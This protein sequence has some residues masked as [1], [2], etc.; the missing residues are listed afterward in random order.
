MKNAA[1]D[2][3]KLYEDSLKVIADERQKTRELIAEKDNRIVSLNF[4]LDKFRRYLF[5]QKSEKLPI[6]Q[7]DVNQTSLFDYRNHT[8]T[9]GRN[10]KAS[11]CGT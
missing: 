1:T 8:G 10:L 7:V 6:K 3:K 2:Y 9:T 5:G 4:E 11:C